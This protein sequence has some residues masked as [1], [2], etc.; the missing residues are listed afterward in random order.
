MRSAGWKALLGAAVLFALGC[1]Q[2]PHS[3]TAVSGES[4]LKE[5]NA[6]YEY[7]EY[8]KMP[9]P[10]RKEDFAQH[11]DSMPNAFDRV[12]NGE[13][14]VV[15]GIGRSTAPGTG[16]QILAYEKAAPTE[17]GAVLLRNGTVKTMTAEDFAKTPKAK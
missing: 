3:A 7:V 6:V 2:A 12:Q 14:V 17:G 13:I 16:Q 1:S 9:A 10:R 5:L 8:S 4:Q 15:W 11:W